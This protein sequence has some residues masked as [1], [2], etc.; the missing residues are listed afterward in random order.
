MPAFASGTTSS[1]ISRVAPAGEILWTSTLAEL[2]APLTLSDAETKLVTL[3][4]RGDA[5]WLLIRA[6]KTSRHQ[7]TDYYEVEHRLV[8][9]DVKTGAAAESHTVKQKP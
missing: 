7:Q 3:T 4:P 8:R 6:S 9:L 2:A 5:A 1:Q